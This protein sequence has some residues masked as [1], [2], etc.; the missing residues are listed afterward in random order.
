MPRKHMG[1][2]ASLLFPEHVHP[3]AVDHS[4]STAFDFSALSFYSV[5]SNYFTEIRHEK[6]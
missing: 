1:A 6:A 2:I 3:K 4:W 5:L